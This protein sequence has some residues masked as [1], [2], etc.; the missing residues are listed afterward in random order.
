VNR[1][2]PLGTQFYNFY[3]SILANSPPVRLSHHYFC[4]LYTLLSFHTFCDV[5]NLLHLNLFMYSRLVIRKMC[6]GKYLSVYA[7][8]CVHAVTG[9]RTSR[10]SC[11][12]CKRSRERSRTLLMRK[13]RRC[14]NLR[15]ALKNR[16][17]ATLLWPNY[18]RY[19]RFKQ[20]LESCSLATTMQCS[21]SYSLSV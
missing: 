7:Q 2:C 21:I 10:L 3:D 18:T 20:F 14:M 13:R 9:R 5:I 19:W 16:F 15:L 1:K 17:L 12:G 6:C 11:V 8:V 4:F